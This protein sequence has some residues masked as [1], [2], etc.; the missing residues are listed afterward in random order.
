MLKWDDIKIGKKVRCIL[1]GI[2]FG[3][4]GKISRVDFDGFGNKFWEVEDDS[5]YSIG[6]T[7]TLLDSFE[8][9]SESSAIK[10]RQMELADLKVGA[11]VICNFDDASIKGFVGKI[12]HVAFSPSNKRLMVYNVQALDGSYIGVGGWTKLSSFDIIVD[13]DMTAEPEP[14]PPPSKKLEEII[15]EVVQ[16]NRPCPSY[17]YGLR[18]CNC[19]KCAVRQQS[20]RR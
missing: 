18:A 12:S 13:D 14:E 5:G 2:C 8:L 17:Y 19:G 6:V 16:D 7:W 15:E 9:V 3:L 1:P 20:F 10:R 4:I 11:K